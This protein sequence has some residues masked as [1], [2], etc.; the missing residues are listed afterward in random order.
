MLDGSAVQIDLLASE[1]D[2]LR[3]YR[4]GPAVAP[5]EDAS[6]RAVDLAFGGVG[7]RPYAPCHLRARPDGVGGLRMA[8]VRRTR[9]GGDSWA[10]PEVP[11]GEAREAYLVRVLVG[12]AEVRRAE[13]TRPAWDYGAEDRAGDGAAGACTIEVAQLSDSY[14]PGPAGR[15]EIDG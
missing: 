3:R 11:L 14:G 2:L 4:Y 8:W 12:G 9:V 13:V 10:G 6:Y 1:R 5:P 7:L 15:I